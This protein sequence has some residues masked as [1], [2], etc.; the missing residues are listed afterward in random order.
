MSDVVS[1]DT[2]SRMM[3][4]IKGKD[5]RPELIIRRGLHSKGFR[6][7]LHTRDL[8]GKPDLDLP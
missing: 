6:Y 1:R 4:G 2:R 8:P 7:K 5:T 3:A